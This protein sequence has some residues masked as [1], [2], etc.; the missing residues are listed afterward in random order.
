MTQLLTTG[1]Y[2]RNMARRTLNKHWM[3]QK[4]SRLE[5]KAVRELRWAF[6]ARLLSLLYNSQNFCVA[7]ICSYVHTSY[8]TKDQST[9]LLKSISCNSGTLPFLLYS[10]SFQQCSSLQQ[11]FFLTSLSLPLDYKILKDF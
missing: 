9:M 8:I 4:R 5:G 10:I 6:S 2:W 11:Y 7:G 1:A 3:S